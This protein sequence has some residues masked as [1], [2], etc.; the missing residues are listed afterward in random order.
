MFKYFQINL[1][2]TLKSGL[3]AAFV[4]CLFFSSLLWFFAQSGT[5]FSKMFLGFAPWSLMIFLA[6][7]V[8]IEIFMKFIGDDELVEP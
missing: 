7:S 5:S 2:R 1:W 8:F 3:L 4:W 6:S